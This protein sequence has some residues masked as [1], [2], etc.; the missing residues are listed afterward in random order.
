MEVMEILTKWA[1]IITHANDAA[2]KL[3]AD[4]STTTHEVRS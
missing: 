2:D 1:K 3:N 4:G